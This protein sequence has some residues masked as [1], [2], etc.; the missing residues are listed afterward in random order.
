MSVPDDNDAPMECPV[1][2][3]A[4]LGKLALFC[5]LKDDEGVGSLSQARRARV[6]RNP[7]TAEDALKWADKVANRS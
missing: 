6:Q 5:H 3:Q 7:W 4:F 2:G 1:C